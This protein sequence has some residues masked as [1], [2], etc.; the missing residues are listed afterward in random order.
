VL[1]CVAH[2]SGYL[3]R[4]LGKHDNLGIGRRMPLINTMNF[5]VTLRNGNVLTRQQLG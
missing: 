4:S 2:H 5:Q 3:F 1:I